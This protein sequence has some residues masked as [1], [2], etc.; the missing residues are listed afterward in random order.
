MLANTILSMLIMVAWTVEDC[1]IHWQLVQSLLP[2]NKPARASAGA[3]ERHP[4]WKDKI[5]GEK[6]AHQGKHR[7]TAQQGRQRAHH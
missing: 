4:S 2:G 5:Q 7:R 6:D 3:A 1:D